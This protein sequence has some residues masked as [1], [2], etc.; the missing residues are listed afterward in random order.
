M[1]LMPNYHQAKLTHV[2]LAEQQVH[3]DWLL[4]PFSLCFPATTD[5]ACLQEKP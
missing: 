4:L 2:V 1:E 5:P 3:S